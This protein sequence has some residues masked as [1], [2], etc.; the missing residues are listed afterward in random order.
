MRE[1]DYEFAVGK[2]HGFCLH[3]LTLK[4]PGFLDPSHSR[5]GGGGGFRPQ[6][7]GNRLTKYQVYG[8]SG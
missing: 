3:C 2:E 7:L 5:G 1:H 4:E 8:T 6:D